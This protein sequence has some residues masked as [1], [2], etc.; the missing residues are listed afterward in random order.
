MLDLRFRPD[1]YQSREPPEYDHPDLP[2][3]RGKRQHTTRRHHR[4]RSPRSI[5]AQT[6]RHPP[7]RLRHH[8]HR[9]HLQPLQYP[10]RQPVAQTRHP[11]REQDQRDRRGQSKTGPRRQ[12]TA[13]TG[14]R[15]PHTNPH[16][17]ARRPR[18]KLAQRHQIRVGRFAQ[19]LPPRHK[20]SPEV[21]RGAPPARQTKSARA[22]GKP[23]KPQRRNGAHPS[24]LT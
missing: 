11:Q 22:G 15:K 16:L 8:R 21:T 14:T 6:P 10:R 3:R 19:P 23:G 12:R 20:F 17:A 7:N 9:H 18:Q 2:Q 1:Q 13:Q 4:Q 24:D 5:R